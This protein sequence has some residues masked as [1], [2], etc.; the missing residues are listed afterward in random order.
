MSCGSTCS[1]SHPPI[2]QAR[3]VRQT[4]PAAAW[5]LPSPFEVFGWLVEL[6][7]LWRRRE[8]LR[9]LSD[10]QLRD[11]GLRRDQIERE[12]RRPFW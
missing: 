11:V 1:R 7:R 2:L 4:R 5:H 3:P 8:E 9:D 10:A 6:Q 12:A